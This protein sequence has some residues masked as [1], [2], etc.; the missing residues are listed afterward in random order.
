MMSAV[1]APAAAT[2]APG[3][4]VAYARG[5][6]AN[7]ARTDP[8]EMYFVSQT[9]PRKI[10]SAGATAIGVNTENAPHAV[11]TPFPPRNRSHTG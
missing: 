6:S 2:S 10:A 1:A 3:L 8:N 7:D 5:G 11:A 4:P 9:V